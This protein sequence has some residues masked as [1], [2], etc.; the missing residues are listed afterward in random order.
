MTRM[1]ARSRGASPRHAESQ[2]TSANATI[3]MTNV[4]WI[5][6]GPLN[7]RIAS[8]GTSAPTV[9]DTAEETAAAQGEV[10]SSELRP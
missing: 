7:S 8:R 5:F 3:T 9:K 4:A 6:H 10:N 1:T 2:P